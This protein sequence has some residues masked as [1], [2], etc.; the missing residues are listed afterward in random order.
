MELHV[1]HLSFGAILVLYAMFL[2]PAYFEPMDLIISTGWIALAYAT[3]GDAANII[4]PIWMLSGYLALVFGLVL[5]GKGF[6]GLGV[7]GDLGKKVE[8]FIGDH[9]K[10]TAIMFFAI[11][12]LIFTGVLTTEIG[13]ITDNYVV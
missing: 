4:V 12:L 2:T 1:K 5:L 7:F 3:F 11:L 13:I 10:T 8:I 6:H 9:P